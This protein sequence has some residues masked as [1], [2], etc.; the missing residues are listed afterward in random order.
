MFG[1]DDLWELKETL[2]ACGC[3]R[4]EFK[5]WQRQYERLMKQLPSVRRQYESALCAAQ[6]IYDTA[7]ELEQ[8]LVEA[9]EAAD[10]KPDKESTKDFAAMLKAL[11]KLQST[12]DHEFVIGRDDREFHSTYESILKLGA[13]ALETPQQRLILQSE[14]ENLLSLLKEN[15]EREKPGLHALCF[16]YQEHSDEELM[17][18]PPAVRL[19][20]IAQVYRT[21]F[22]DPLSRMME[23]IPQAEHGL[24]EQMMLKLTDD[25]DDSEV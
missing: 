19:E 7:R 18:L 4:N 13:K 3:D 22:T 21:E 15:L 5:S 14:I 6:E 20:R 11:K 8:M 25:H 12:C 23:C 9:K 2:L 24:R 16:F 17:E 1:K 10:G